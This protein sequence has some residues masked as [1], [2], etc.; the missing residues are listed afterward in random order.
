M[1]GRAGGPVRARRNAGDAVDAGPTGYRGKRLLDLALAVPALMLLA[2]VMLAVAGLVAWRLGRPVLFRQLR[3]GLRGRL[4]T[5][6][7]FRTMTD[8]R[9][10][11]GR[12]LPD[13]ERLTRLGRLLRGLSLDELPELFNVLRGEMSLVGPRPLLPAF[14]DRYTAEE[15]RRHDALPGITGWAQ[16]HGRNGIDWEERFR[17]DVWYVDHR[18]LRLDL[19]ILLMTVRAV[20]SREG[21][22]YPGR[23]TSPEFR[24]QPER[25]A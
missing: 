17:L 12:L 22:A 11:A 4:F 21:I 25:T 18:S 7:K 5:L 16:V 8:G 9:D 1:T 13:A 23:A 19:R 15:A 24:G 6:Y 3:P 14:L 2:P 10:A 20:L